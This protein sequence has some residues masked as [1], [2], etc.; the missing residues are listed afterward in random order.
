MTPTLERY[1]RT[2]HL[3]F[4]PGATSDD[5]IMPRLD[6]LLAEDDIVVT[7]KMD[8]EC[9]TIR[10]HGCHARSPD[11]NHHPSRDWV[12]AF[13]SAFRFQMPDNERFM[14]ENV[15]ARHSIG[16]DNLPS[17]ALGFAWLIDDCFQSW[18][19]TMA[20]FET[21]GIT[22]VPVLYRGPPSEKILR[23]I[24]ASLDTT[25]QEGFVARTSRTFCAADMPRLMGK[26]VRPNHVQTD[27]HWKHA[28]IVPNTLA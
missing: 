10:R 18:D 1:Y 24:A 11:G 6:D 2:L 4:S 26:F 8:G 22:P 19:D 15:F 21:V 5:K 20:A 7:E 25:I 9:T 16:Y 28:A 3:P 17:Y 27:T 12:K 14:V 23:D 13:A